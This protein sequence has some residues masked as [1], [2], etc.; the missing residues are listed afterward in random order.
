ML[1]ER[2]KSDHGETGQKTKVVVQA[3]DDRGLDCGDGV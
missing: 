1:G 3:R 2:G